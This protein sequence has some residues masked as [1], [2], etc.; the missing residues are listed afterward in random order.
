MG[1]VRVAVLGD[2]ELRVD[3]RAVPVTRPRLRALLCALALRA[4]RIVAVPEL[5]AHVWQEGVPDRFRP[6]L[7]T[8]VTQLRKLMGADVLRTVPDGYLLDIPPDAV[9]ALV[10]GRLLDSV[11]ELR[12]AAARPV[13]AEALLLWRGAPAA[14]LRPESATHL[15]ELY[16][17]AVRRRVDIDLELGRHTELTAELSD[18]TSRFP[19]HE[20]LWARLMTAQY[21]SGRY[22]EALDTYQTLRRVLADSLGTDP[23][24]ELRELYALVLAADQDVSRI[25]P[26]QLPSAHPGFVGRRTEL[27]NLDALA[28]G[29]RPNRRTSDVLPL[30]RVGGPPVV[31]AVHGP[32]GAGKTALAL[33]WAHRAYDRFP[34]GSVYVDMRGFG[35]DPA[36]SAGAALA[37]LL[38]AVGAAVLP[39]TVEERAALWRTR[40]YGRRMLVVVDNVRDAAH[41]RPLLPGSSGVTMLVTSRNDLRGL[42]T[43][44]GAHSVAVGEL[45]LDDAVRLGVGT[46]VA[47]ACGRLP[48]A[49]V[50]AADRVARCP[51]LAAE[52][53]RDNP[54]DLLAEPADPAVDLRTV[55]SSSYRAVDPATAAAFRRLAHHPLGEITVMS[56]SAVLGE[57]AGRLLDALASVHLL[58]RDGGVYRLN[59]LFR[60][61]ALDQ[62]RAERK[63]HLVAV[64]E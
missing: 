26:H 13:L 58:E 8:L 24:A 34:D 64:A 38:N 55:L 18:L 46:E 50:V 47:A 4:G 20:P 1:D 11:Q 22:A 3:G 28:D 9:D 61:L 10:F 29:T 15:V 7:H 56:A 41:V 27:S 60:H 17:S 51:G 32:A 21:R 5:A 43:R 31:V 14:Q 39:P 44:D 19:L 54:L 36:V 48:L 2:L 40:L 49:L 6:G 25:V 63:P 35:P 33:H 16:L 12:T 42:V 62:A 59:P 45:P 37:R 57:P 52:L 30:G 23:A 53:V